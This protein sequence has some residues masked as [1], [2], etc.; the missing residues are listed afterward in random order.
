MDLANEMR[1]QEAG[2]IWNGPERKSLE[3]LPQWKSYGIT[4]T[5]I[6][7]Q[8]GLQALGGG[9]DGLSLGYISVDAASSGQPFVH[10]AQELHSSSVESKGNPIRFY[11]AL[12]SY[13]TPYLTVAWPQS[14]S[15]PER[16][17]SARSIVSKLALLFGIGWGDILKKTKRRHQ[18]RTPIQRDPC[19]AST[20][21]AAGPVISGLDPMGTRKIHKMAAQ[22]Y[23]QFHLSKVPYLTS[24]TAPSNP[25]VQ[26]D[27]P[28][29]NRPTTH[30]PLLSLLARLTC[31][32][33]C[34]GVRVDLTASASEYNVLPS[35]L[36]A[37]STQRQALNLKLALQLLTSV[38]HSLPKLSAYHIRSLNPHG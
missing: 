38:V 2:F 26:R 6:K 10:L 25:T 36:E 24:P 27:R 20:T 29:S 1:R 34:C 22:D 32:L 35:N 5:E 8:L 37:P 33:L 12:R 14:N 13:A 9:L 28:P 15:Y 16:G 11:Q 31:G 18:S 4:L 3:D 19:G 7:K 30:D 21:C 23:V 17:Q